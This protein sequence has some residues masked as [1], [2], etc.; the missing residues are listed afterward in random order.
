LYELVNRNKLGLGVDLKQPA[1]RA[2]AQ[3]LMQ[4]ADVLVENFRHGVA[5][6][7]GIG[8]ADCAHLNPRLIYASISGFGQEG[9]NKDLP[10]FDLNRLEADQV[11]HGDPA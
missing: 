10:A 9:K 2:L 11:L 1:G 5:A 8:Y 4:S 7:L 6:R 3:R